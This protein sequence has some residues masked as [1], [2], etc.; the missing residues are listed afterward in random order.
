MST[1]VRPEPPN[2]REKC[3]EHIVEEEVLAKESL[4]LYLLAIERAVYASS[5]RQQRAESRREYAR[6]SGRLHNRWRKW[7]RT[8]QAAQNAHGALYYYVTPHGAYSTRED[9][10][11]AQ[12]D[13]TPPVRVTTA[14]L[15]GQEWW[16]TCRTF[17]P[18]C[19]ERN[20]AG[21]TAL[22]EK[23]PRTHRQ[24]V[25]FTAVYMPDASRACS[26][27]NAI[28]HCS[29]P[30]LFVICKTASI[31]FDMRHAHAES[32]RAG[33]K[34]V[35][36]VRSFEE[37]VDAIVSDAELVVNAFK[38]MTICD[39]P[40]PSSMESAEPTPPAM[41]DAQD[42]EFKRQALDDIRRDVPHS[43]PVVG[44]LNQYMNPPERPSRSAEEIAEGREKQKLRIIARNSQPMPL[45][46]PE[47]P[48]ARSAEEIRERRANLMDRLTAKKPDGRCWKEPALLAKPR[49]RRPDS[50]RR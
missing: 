24:M 12:A 19:Q 8:I 40:Y 33:A 49:T 18:K 14:E 41:T 1:D 15:A 6:E 23:L 26:T 29:A 28:P 45:R 17:H 25:G 3:L 5:L 31:Y 30:F 47:E 9:C 36:V 32:R 27:S 34:E 11:A 43:E 4:R 42:R 39:I 21:R 22:Q 48:P 44:W 37:A 35:H 38:E 2:L 16:R 7:R 50:L 13:K 10:L 20:V 46:L